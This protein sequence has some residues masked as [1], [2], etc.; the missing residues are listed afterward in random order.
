MDLTEHKK[1]LRRFDR[2]LDKLDRRILVELAA[3]G[4]EVTMSELIDMVNPLPESNSTWA[5]IK[6]MFWDYSIRSFY[7]STNAL[8][9]EGFLETGRAP[10]GPERSYRE[11]R[12]L[13]ITDKGSDWVRDNVTV[14]GTNKKPGNGW[15][16]RVAAT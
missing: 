9:Q 13:R 1:H 14:T 10:G 6:T 8:R 11:Q 15:F 16:S 3:S 7:R 12:T 2:P 4:S 5:W